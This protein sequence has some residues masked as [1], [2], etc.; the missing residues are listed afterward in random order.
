MAV[1]LG[2][3]SLGV[4]V[5]PRASRGIVSRLNLSPWLEVLAFFDFKVTGQGTV[6]AEADLKG[7]TEP[8]SVD[9]GVDGARG[10]AI[11][12]GLS[13]I[14]GNEPSHCGRVL[15]GDGQLSILDLRARVRELQGVNGRLCSELILIEVIFVLDPGHVSTFHIGVREDDVWTPPKGAP[16]TDFLSTYG[17]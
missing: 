1:G 6:F 11:G 14:A 5:Q 8:V 17:A 13:A 12:V 4:E 9:G 15:A 10:G 3:G 7:T 2:L 16:V